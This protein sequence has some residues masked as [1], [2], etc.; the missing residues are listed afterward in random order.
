MCVG[1][2]CGDEMVIMVMVYVCAN[3]C[4]WRTMRIFKIFVFRV[5]KYIALDVVIA[6]VPC[7]GANVSTG[8]V[9]TD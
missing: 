7:D 1:V 6:N 9:L 3:A 4:G 5:Y 8:N 2:S